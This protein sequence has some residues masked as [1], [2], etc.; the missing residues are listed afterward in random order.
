MRT[1]ALHG[2]A[3]KIVAGTDV[4]L[5]RVPLGVAVRAGAAKPD[6]GS[7]EAFKPVPLFKRRETAQSVGNGPGTRLRADR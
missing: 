4:D 3:D 7:A 1:R 6:V 2:A 5:A